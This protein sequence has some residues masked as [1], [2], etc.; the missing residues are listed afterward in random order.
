MVEMRSGAWPKPGWGCWVAPILHQGAEFPLS[1]GGKDPA[2]LAGEVVVHF[3][4]NPLLGVRDLQAVPGQ[5]HAPGEVPRLLP[6]PP[7]NRGPETRSLFTDDTC[8]SR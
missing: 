2:W 3:L 4:S 7:A 8:P 6:G 1:R 5:A